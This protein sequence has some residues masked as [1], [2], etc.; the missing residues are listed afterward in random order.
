MLGIFCRTKKCHLIFIEHLTGM[1]NIRMNSDLHAAIQTSIG[2]QFKCSFCMINLI[3]KNDDA[4]ESI[5]VQRHAPLECGVRRTRAD[6]A[7]GNGC[8]DD[9]HHRRMFL[10]NKKFYRPIVD[11]LI[12]L[13]RNDDL[14]LWAYSRIDTV[15]NPEELAKVRKAGIRWLCLGIEKRR[16]GDTPGGCE[17]QV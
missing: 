4:P 9:P 1:L 5:A 13:N 16:Q 11:T 12:R 10:L 14:K 17:R 6:Q 3:N 7:G 2:C 8:E 15:P